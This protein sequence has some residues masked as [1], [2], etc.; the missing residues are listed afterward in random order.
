MTSILQLL[1]ALPGLIKTITELM[2]LAEEGFG[3]G[4]G[5][6][7]KQ[8]VME[9]IQAMVANADIWGRVQSV[10]SGVINAVALFR[11]GGSGKEPVK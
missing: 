1:T 7:K 3:A 10:I 9:A 4:K 2:E 8:S 11:F 6:E 5:G